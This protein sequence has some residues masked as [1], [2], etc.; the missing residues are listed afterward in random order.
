MTTNIKPGT[1]SFTGDHKRLAKF[2]EAMTGLAARFRWQG[3]GHGKCKR[4]GS[5]LALFLVSIMGCYAAIG[6]DAIRPLPAETLVNS[7]T[8]STWSVPAISPDGQWIAYLVQ[9]GKNVNLTL[10]VKDPAYVRFVAA[11]LGMAS[12]LWV[13]NTRTGNAQNITQGRGYNWG[14]SWSPNGKYL[15]YFS[16]RDGTPNLWVWEPASR[17]TRKVSDALIRANQPGEVAKWTKD[18]SR[19][20]VK[21]L[22]EGMTFE[23]LAE[24]RSKGTRQREAHGG[25]DDANVTVFQWPESPDSKSATYSETTQP[26]AASERYV[27]DLGLIDVR[28]GA[29][30]RVVKGIKPSWYSFS[31]DESMIAFVT[32][33][34]LAGGNSWRNQFD[35]VVKNLAGGQHITLAENIESN[36]IVHNSVSWSPDGKWLAYTDLR[37]SAKGGCFIVSPAGGSPRRVSGVDQPDFFSI[38]RPP[39]WSRDSKNFYLLADKAVWR[40][41]PDAEKAVEVGRVPN[42][43]VLFIVPQRKPEDSFWSPRDSGSLVVLTR[44]ESTRTMGFYDVN[45]VTGNTSKLYEGETNIA[46][47]LIDASEAGKSIAFAAQDAQHPNEVWFS[48]SS[49]RNPRRLTAIDPELAR[50]KTGKS[51]I[52]EWSGPDGKTLRGAV[53]LPVNYEP[54]K[55][56]PLIVNVYGGENLSEDVNEFGLSAFGAFSANLQPLSA[57]GYAILAP[58]APLRVGTPMQDIAKTVMPGVDKAIELGIADPERLGVMGRSYGGY[59]TLALLVQTTRFKAAISWAG[60]SNLMSFYGHMDEDGTATWTGWAEASQGRMGGTPWEYRD[61]YVENSPIFYLDRVTTPVLLG[62]GTKDFDRQ[63][64]ETFVGLRRLNKEVTYVKYENEGH[65]LFKPANQIDWWN[66]VL[67]WFDKYLKATEAPKTAEGR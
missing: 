67:A 4:H 21:V 10:D 16:D 56:Y 26:T 3:Y 66:R 14:P 42:K 58:D 51:R 48:D 43:Q 33:K 27:A 6:Q 49:F 64:D 5:Y 24:I 12:D 37:P 23:Q 45:V 35:L 31:P 61:R 62:I 25:A 41:S 53:L 39:L 44:D 29:L 32:S 15:A 40:L 38:G 52:I 46:A 7:K 2:Y 55:R 22:P 34:G 1:V 9:D 47:R 63:G 28:S 30:T 65:V 8:L 18:G 13:V 17:T 59:S 57:R 11:G 20:L 19:I 36:G 50:Y 60:I 54:G